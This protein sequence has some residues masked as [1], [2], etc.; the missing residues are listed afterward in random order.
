MKCYLLLKGGMKAAKRGKHF[1]RNKV[2]L[3]LA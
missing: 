2:C 3:L 1:A